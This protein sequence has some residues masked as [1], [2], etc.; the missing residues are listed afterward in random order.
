MQRSSSIKFLPIHNISPPY[1]LITTP[2]LIEKNS[3]P[4]Y[5]YNVHTNPQN[6]LSPCHFHLPPLSSPPYLQNSVSRDPILATPVRFPSYTMYGNQL[7]F[8]PI[9]PPH[10]NSDDI[11]LTSVN[12]IIKHPK[13][14]AK[15]RS[16]CRFPPE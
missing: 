5:F 14:T 3:L 12:S 10:L 16:S 15:F 7:T 1:L 13:Y 9:T 4:P 8:Y 6:N 2:Q 11:P